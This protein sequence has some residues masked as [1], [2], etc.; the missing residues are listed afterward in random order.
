MVLMDSSPPQSVERTLSNAPARASRRTDVAIVVRYAAALLALALTYTAAARGGLKLDA[1]AGFATLVWAPTGIALAATL[2]F[3]YRLWPA[4]FAGAFVANLWA[5]APLLAAVGIACGNTLEA[6]AGAALL[7]RIP[8]FRVQL[9]RLEDVASLIILAAALC[10]TISASV[11]VASLLAAGTIAPGQIAVTWR[12]WWLG[13]LVGALIVAPLLLVWLTTRPL[14]VPAARVAE[15][16]AVFGALFCIDA[17][18]FRAHPLGG[19]ASIEQSYLVFPGLIYAAL[20]YGQRGAVTGVFVTTAIAVWS[21]VSGYGPFA[22]P[23][24]SE[25]LFGLQTFMAVATA[26]FLVFGAAVA[27]R[28]RTEEWLRHA[29]EVAEEANRAKSDFFAV[30]SHELR[31]PLNAIS[32]YIELLEMELAGPM[33]RKQREYLAR[34]E[35]SQSHLHAL[36]EE[37]LGFTR[38]ETGRLTL[39][40]QPV[41]VYDA[42][43]ALEGVVQAELDDKRL[44]FHREV[45]DQSLVARADPDKLRQVLLNLLTNGMKFTPEGGRITIG[46]A[47][48]L[49]KVR[50][51]I[52][53]TGIGIAPD[54][55]ENVFEPFF[56]VERGPTRSYSGMGLGLSIA[57]DLARA[58]NGEVWLESVVGAGCTAWLTLPS[59]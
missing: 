44:T 55:L 47:R 45:H 59:V 19:S 12:A 3:G 52:A 23:V 41:I 21:T 16:V 5:G 50:L 57:R 8:G 37:V 48:E 20:R 49:D 33:T 43:V 4:I 53:D 38:L 58:M 26:T 54:Q 51:W 11:G 36:L 42:I 29:R 30:M 24:L 32:G 17:Y 1:I 27:E 14:W 6:L 2:L 28:Q 46:A 18:I 9:D 56:Q 34:I 31:T 25:G 35:K 10:T 7:R 39:S 22:R 13:D 40:L 15:A